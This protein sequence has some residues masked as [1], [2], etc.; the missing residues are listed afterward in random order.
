MNAAGV[1]F[2]NAELNHVRN[3][4]SN[5]YEQLM[6]GKLQIMDTPT[7]RRALAN[8]LKKFI[9]A[10]ESMVATPEPKVFIISD[11]LWLVEKALGQDLGAV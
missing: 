2:T 1:T 4:F 5:W 9:K 8:K 10:T 6:S 11:D 7:Q 3:E